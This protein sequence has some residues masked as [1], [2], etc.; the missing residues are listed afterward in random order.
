MKT[1]SSEPDA[2][3]G[4]VLP[5]C[6]KAYAST[7]IVII[8]PFL[9]WSG[10]NLERDY[11]TLSFFFD[12]VPDPSL[13]SSNELGQ[14]GTMVWTYHA[15]FVERACQDCH[16]NPK[17][18]NVGLTREDSHV[19]LKCHE[20]VVDQ[21]EMMHG[22]VVGVGCLFCHSPHKSPFPS[23]LREP[24]PQLCVQCHTQEMMRKPLPQEHMD[25]NRNCL[26]CHYGHGGDID[27]FLRPSAQREETD[28]EV[29]N[30]GDSIGQ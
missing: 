23:L 10:C 20:N 25:P 7:A 16:P 27:Y 11:E 19:C 26:D 4:R 13:L 2:S 30:Q 18:S 1:R 21:Y 9:L 15:P 28:T 14:G 6:T 5:L 12:G 17:Y 29:T 24:T 22:P 3:T 8:L